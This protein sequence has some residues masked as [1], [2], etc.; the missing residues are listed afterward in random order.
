MG[1]TFQELLERSYYEQDAGGAPEE[2]TEADRLRQKLEEAI[3]DIPHVGRLC[4][5]KTDEGICT[6]DGR[7]CCYQM[8][9][10]CKQWEWRGEK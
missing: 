7:H 8:H 3:N 4:K 2:L 10:P 9:T 1:M 6:L 5:H